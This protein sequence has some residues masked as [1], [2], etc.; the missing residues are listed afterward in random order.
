MEIYYY[1]LC[2]CFFVLFV[3]LCL[4]FFS[5][6]LSVTQS[7]LNVIIWTNKIIIHFN[8]H[9]GTIY[10]RRKSKWFWLES[11]FLICL[12]LV[13]PLSTFLHFFYF[14]SLFIHRRKPKFG[15]ESGIFGLCCMLCTVVL[16][17][18][19]IATKTGGQHTTYTKQSWKSSMKLE[20]NVLQW[21]WMYIYM[22]YSEYVEYGHQIFRACIHVIWHANITFIIGHHQL[23]NM[24]CSSSDNQWAKK[25]IWRINNKNGTMNQVD[26]HWG[27]WND[28]YLFHF[29]FLFRFSFP[30]AV[31]FIFD[32]IFI[33]DCSLFMVHMAMRG[34]DGTKWYR[35]CHLLC[36]RFGREMKKK[37]NNIHINNEI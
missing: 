12:F 17:L 24:Q 4:G 18:V 19:C 30:L 11:V 8:F 9:I 26:D 23:V 21:I 36:S 13:F 34:W 33:V 27:K 7:H 10:C 25:C 37:N 5:I 3:V 31:P 16:L 20:L 2:E 22:D 28:Y 14:F 29:I 32:V 6:S 15:M 1:V 35:H